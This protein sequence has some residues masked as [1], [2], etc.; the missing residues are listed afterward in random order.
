MKP[1]KRLNELFTAPATDLCR[2]KA[3]SLLR[4][5]HETGKDLIVIKNS[6][7]Y[8]VVLSYQKYIELTNEE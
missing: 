8:A 5:M 2:G 4:E 7:P 3:P 1:K 6:K